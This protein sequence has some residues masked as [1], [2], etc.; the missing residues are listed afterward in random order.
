MLKIATPYMLTK[1]GKWYICGT[2]HPY[3]LKEPDNVETL[4]SKSII[5]FT[6]NDD[7]YK[8]TNIFNLSDYKL[9]SLNEIL[10]LRYCKVRTSNLLFGGDNN[11]IYFRLP[12]RDECEVL[13]WLSVIYNFIINYDDP[14][15]VINHINVCYDVKFLGGKL[16]YVKYKDVELKALSKEEFKKIWIK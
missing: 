4:D 5:W 6:E 7:L 15:F 14:E 13:E 16:E 11:D 9:K 8:D 1:G 10:N 12:T 2:C 3:L